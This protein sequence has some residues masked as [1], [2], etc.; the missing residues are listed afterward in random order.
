MSN[1]KRAFDGFGKQNSSKRNFNYG[2]VNQGNKIDDNIDEDGVEIPTYKMTNAPDKK[3]KVR[4]AIKLQMQ[5][6]YPEIGKELRT[7]EL[8]KYSVGPA[9]PEEE[10]TALPP[11]GLGPR[12]LANFSR[13]DA[14]VEGLRKRWIIEQGVY[15]KA[16]REAKAFIKKTYVAPSVLLAI[17]DSEII[18]EAE[19][20]SKSIIDFIDALELAIEKNAKPSLQ[21]NERLENE[22]AEVERNIK[23]KRIDNDCAKYLVEIK[24][25]M[26][27]WRGLLEEEKIISLPHNLTEAN[28]QNQVRKIKAEVQKETD[29]NKEIIG[30]IYSQ[31]KRF[32]MDA[33]TT[34]Y[35]DQLEV[36]MK[37]NKS[38]SQSTP[39]SRKVD[40]NGVV[41]GGVDIMID[42][43]LQM[44]RVQEASKGD[45]TAIFYVMKKSDGERE[46]KK[47]QL[48]IANME[49]QNSCT[50]CKDTLKYV[51][52]CQSHTFDK[53][54]YNPANTVGY[55]G[56][57]KKAEVVK[58]AEEY[59]GRQRSLQ[60]QGGRGRGGRDGNRRR[61]K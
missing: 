26:K 61:G 20:D 60:D 32:G 37:C 4:E 19:D 50:F 52:A 3:M 44:V 5:I 47:K 10:Y 2:K 38:D 43:L 27:Q 24:L 25:L 59:R 17:Q 41:T 16:V 7:N 22:I 48:S 14:N 54:K 1:K 39:F 9:I 28:R 13:Y 35:Y 33:D 58:K 51:R 40:A 11:K 23:F 46:L 55:V 12:P 53:C 49:V 18:M 6:L 42:E 30:R 34:S 15:I 31:I 21:E 56:D 29:R 57:E 8:S 45:G 36:K